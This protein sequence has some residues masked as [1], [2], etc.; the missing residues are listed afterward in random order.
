M[1]VVG[2][3]KTRVVVLLLMKAKKSNPA[4][5]RGWSAGSHFAARRVKQFSPVPVVRLSFTPSERARVKGG[6]KERKGSPLP[7]PPSERALHYNKRKWR[8]EIEIYSSRPEEEKIFSNRE[9]T[10][11]R[12]RESTQHSICEPRDDNKMNTPHQ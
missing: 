1:T 12:G 6:R 11:L 3:N 8:A 2:P 4:W 10:Q 9:V 7:L 5:E